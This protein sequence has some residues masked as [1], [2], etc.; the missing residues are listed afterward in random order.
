MMKL[1]VLA[2]AAVLLPGATFCSPASD[3]RETGIAIAQRA[4]VPANLTTYSMRGIVA[5]VNQRNDTIAI[6]L[7][8]DET[9]SFRVQD[10]LLFDSVRYGDEVEITVQNIAGAKTIVG[11]RNE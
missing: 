3:E 8:Q 9:E 7:A 4:P 2:A 10:G 1:T 6:Q 11:L 5:G